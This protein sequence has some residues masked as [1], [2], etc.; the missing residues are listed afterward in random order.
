MK[1]LFTALIV[2]LPIITVYKSPIKGIDLGTFIFILLSFIIIYYSKGKIF[3]IKPL[4]VFLV[5]IILSTLVSILIQGNIESYMIMLRT[6]KFVLLIFLI[7]FMGYKELFD[8]DFGFKMLKIINILAV[9]Y[10]ILQVISY[11]FFKV[12]LPTGILSL[13]TSDVYYQLDYQSVAANFY[14][15]SSFFIEPAYFS[16]YV[17]LYLCYSIFGGNGTGVVKNWK[18]A[19][20]ISSGIILSGSGQGILLVVTIWGIWFLSTLGLSKLNLKKISMLMTISFMSI[21]I[22]KY[23]LQT[24][25]VSKA[26]LRVFSDNTA[27]GG[28]AVLSRVGG[29]AYFYMLP[30]IFKFI[31]MGYGNVPT[32]VYFN[33]ASYTLYCSGI[34]GAVIVLYILWSSFI[35]GKRFQRVF[36]IIFFILIMGANVFTAASICFYFS[37]IYANETNEIINKEERTCKYIG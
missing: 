2:M 16:Q 10:I 21:F 6:G 5:Y 34:L 9:I 1:K 25:V 19:V 28:N 26:L 17:L 20:F 32:G 3:V 35:K 33:S 24:E 7:L 27:G 22:M 13:V 30:N 18:L 29:Y 31:G 8:S 15:P 14:R 36:V 12:L 11:K 37:F 23:L 4:F